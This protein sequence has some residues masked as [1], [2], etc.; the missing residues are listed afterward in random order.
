MIVVAEP[1]LEKDVLE[2]AGIDADLDGLMED[3]REWE[4]GCVVH[5]CGCNCSC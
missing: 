4:D 3:V 5:L 2:P 1:R